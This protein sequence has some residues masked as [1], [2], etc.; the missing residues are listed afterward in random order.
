MF[1]CLSFLCSLLLHHGLCLSCEQV[2]HPS[3]LGLLHHLS[4]RM[5]TALFTSGWLPILGWVKC[6]LALVVQQNLSPCC[7]PMF[8]LIS[9][10][11]KNC[12]DRCDDSGL[13]FCLKVTILHPTTSVPLHL[14]NITQYCPTHHSH[15]H[16][17][18]CYF[19]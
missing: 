16:S 12:L 10:Y 3:T 4:S 8:Q 11:Y 17:I 7:L 5:L 2:F 14:A 1:F 18:V 13:S 15:Q 19:P 9:H 6:P